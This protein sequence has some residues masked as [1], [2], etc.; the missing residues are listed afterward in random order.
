MTR[1][2]APIEVAVVED[3]PLYRDALVRVL[4]ETGRIAVVVA[5]HS[6]ERLLAEPGPVPTVVVLD[7][8]LPGRS[9]P[10]AVHHLTSL[11]HRVLAVSASDDRDEVMAA[12]SAGARGYVPKSADAAEI[13]RAVEAVAQGGN[14]V[15]PG[16]AATLLSAGPAAEPAHLP[17]LSDR[18]RQV[19]GLLADGERDF[20]IAQE[21]GI[22]VRTV[23]SH[24]D[25]IREKTGRRRRPDLTRYA[26]E[27][28]ILRPAES[29]R[30]RPG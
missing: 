13:G 21:L 8:H 10:N 24:L 16:L 15:S 18:E 17:A 11:G 6:V 5:T 23:R 4:D 19:L 22:S 9:G 14:Y 2:G 27:E 3:H 25:R 26:I 29:G 7:L 1:A 28:G 20:D 30:A 12:L